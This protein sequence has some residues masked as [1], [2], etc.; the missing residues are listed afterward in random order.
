M[1]S[2]PVVILLLSLAAAIL[3]TNCEGANGTG[4]TDGGNIPI[5]I[6]NADPQRPVYSWEF[7]NVAQLDVNRIDG[8]N[9]L[10]R[11]WS[12]KA[13]DRTENRIGAPVTHGILPPG[14]GFFLAD[15]QEVTLESGVTYQLVLTQ[16]QQG[17]STISWQD[18][19]PE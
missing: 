1:K 19:I 6:D 17:S 12:L 7:G 13:I 9:R 8:P 15:S 10:I 14:S 18:F 4:L 2:I 3:L 11:V 16:V 5:E